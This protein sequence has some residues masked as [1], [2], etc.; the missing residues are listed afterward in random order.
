VIAIGE[1]EEQRQLARGQGADHVFD[2]DPSRLRDRVL[3][4]THGHGA[5]VVLEAVGGDIFAGC[6]RCIAWE[7]RLVVI[8]FASGDIPTIHAGHVLVK[9]MSVIGLQSS[10]YRDRDAAGLRQTQEALLALYRDGAVRVDI[11]A[12]YPLEAASDALVAIEQGRSR[13]KLVLT[14]GIA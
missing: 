8:G 3:E 12:T 11:S 13:G 7:G 2:A 14:T 1:T 10:D 5:D 6:M 9:N 4:V